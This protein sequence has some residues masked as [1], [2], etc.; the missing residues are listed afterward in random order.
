M[1]TMQVIPST[2]K[3]ANR[4][5]TEWHSHSGPSKFHKAAVAIRADGRV[6]AVAI[7]GRP[8]ARML[9]DD[10][11][12]EVL[13]VA[14]DRYPNACSA[15]YAAGRRL[16][17]ALGYRRVISYTLA[18]E[19][20]ACLRAAGFRKEAAS[21]GGTWSRSSRLRNDPDPRSAGPKNRWVWP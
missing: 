2:L 6:V 17:A 8:K 18:E 3:E 20:G 4:L 5:V 19:C 15:A 14:T 16:G 13:R 11:T 9:D 7:V 12:C 21:G 10:E 1:T